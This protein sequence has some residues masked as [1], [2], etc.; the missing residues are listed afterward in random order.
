[1]RTILSVLLL[2]GLS[3]SMLGCDTGKPAG[4]GA[5]IPGSLM[6]TPKEGPKPAGAAPGGAAAPNAAAQ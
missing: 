3:A 5:T 1:M 6:P 4:G 2:A